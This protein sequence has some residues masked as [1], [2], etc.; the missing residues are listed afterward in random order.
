MSNAFKPFT[1]PR[2]MEFQNSIYFAPEVQISKSNNTVT[3]LGGSIC[4]AG[5]GRS[6]A[7][8][9]FRLAN[10]AQ[11]GVSVNAI[12]RIALQKYSRKN[13]MPGVEIGKHFLKQIARAAIPEMVVRI[14]D[15]K[16]GLNYGFAPPI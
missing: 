15:R 12:H 16:L 10:G 4:P 7:I 9:E 5:G 11:Y 14:N 1:S 6:N 8:H 13:S 2:E 3:N